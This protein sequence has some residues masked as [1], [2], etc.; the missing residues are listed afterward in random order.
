MGESRGHGPAA[1]G[2]GVKDGGVEYPAAAV[3]GSLTM[4]GDQRNDAAGEH[5]TKQ[6]SRWAL[7]PPHTRGST[8]RLAVR[9]SFFLCPP[10]ADAPSA[11]Q[12]ESGKQR[13]DVLGEASCTALQLPAARAFSPENRLRQLS[14][15]LG[16]TRASL[17][18]RS[19]G[20]T[21]GG[22]ARKGASICEANS[23]RERELKI[24]YLKKKRLL[25]FRSGPAQKA[26]CPYADR[27][28]GLGFRA[29]FVAGVA[30]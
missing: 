20:V 13:V 2:G 11:L 18:S 29:W 17:R 8:P 27:R 9:P 1:I 24:K 23:L 26:P 5:W 7:F 16:A 4:S 12:A 30:Q 25:G 28:Q 6:V 14:A 3:Y 15:G 10:L 22:R 21:D 19:T